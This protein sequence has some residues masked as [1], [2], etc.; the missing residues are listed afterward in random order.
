MIFPYSSLSL[1]YICPPFFISFLRA[2][3]MQVHFTLME[4]R[5]EVQRNKLLF[6]KR[7]R[8]KCEG[9]KHLFAGKK[10]F[11]T[12]QIKLIGV[13]WGNWNVSMRKNNKVKQRGK[14]YFYDEIFVIQKKIR[15]NNLM[16]ILCILL[17]I[18]EQEIWWK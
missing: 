11:I 4:D 10:I 12:V 8:M 2:F 17:L 3:T 7:W 16:L 15:K 1:L 9:F 14:P 13:L 6:V 5:N 18:I